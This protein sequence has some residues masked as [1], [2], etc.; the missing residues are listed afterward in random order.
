MKW[1]TYEDLY[2]RQWNA[3]VEGNLGQLLATREKES[4]RKILEYLHIMIM[5]WHK[6]GVSCSKLAIGETSG[7]SK[8][9]LKI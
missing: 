2:T 8:E 4:L 1:N 3:Q 6:G 5:N 7:A 9:G